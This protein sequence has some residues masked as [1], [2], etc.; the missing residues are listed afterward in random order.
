TPRPLVD[1]QGRVFAVL[2]GKPKGES[3]DA[4]CRQAYQAMDAEL[5][6]FDLKEAKRK[7]RRGEYPAL[8]VGVSYGNGQTAPS[9]LASGERGRCAEGLTR[10]LENPSIQ[11]LAAYGDSA[12]HLW[13]PKLYSHYRDC[14]ERMYTALPHLRRNFRMS[15]FPCATF[16]FGP[17]VRTFKHR[18]TLNLA[19]GWC[20]IIALGRFDHKRGGHIVLWDAKLVIEFPAGSTIL[21]PSSA[22]M[23]SNVSVREGESRASFTQYAAGG[24]FRWVDNGCQ[25]QAVFQQ[26]DPVSYD[27]RMQERKDGWQKGLAM[28]SSLNELLTT[29]DQ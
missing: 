3:F 29:S 14:I 5:L 10:L 15:V 22:I 1:S 9:R 18:D 24:I 27:Q 20:S 19:N 8:T 23:H 21:I 2:A 4:D 6:E 28:Y 12:F 17:Q 11:R 25:R 16:N 7:H 26:I 13:V